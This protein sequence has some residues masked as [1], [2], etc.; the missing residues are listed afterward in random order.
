[1]DKTSLLA[2][3][4]RVLLSEERKRGPTDDLGVRKEHVT[5]QDLLRL[6]RRRGGR[7]GVGVWRSSD[8]EDCE[9]EL[10]RSREVAILER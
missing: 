10:G 3:S 8:V 2:L 6:A 1:M 9:G 5:S 4:Q 7:G